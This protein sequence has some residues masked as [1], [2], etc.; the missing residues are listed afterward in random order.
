MNKERIVFSQLMDLFPRHDFNQCVKRYS[1][2]LIPRKFSFFDQYL[3]MSY[4]QVTFRESLRDIEVCL[5]SLGAKTYHM[6]FRSRVTRSTLAYANDTRDWRIWHDFAQ[7]LITRARTLYAGDSL[8]IQFQNAAYAIDSTTITLCLTLFP[9]ARYRT[10]A[11]AIKLHTQLDLRGNIPS[12]IL[13][14]HAKMSDVHF[15][16]EII[17]EPG[18][19]YIMDRGYFDFARFFRF[20][21]EG[22]FFVTRLKTNVYYR[23]VEIFSRSRT[24]AV[25]L[26]TA[27]TPLSK[28]AKKD[29]PQRLRLIE[30]FDIE[31]Q[32]LFVFITNNFALSAQAIA[33]FYRA[34]WKVELFFKWIK[35]HLR[36]KAFFGT[37]ENA[38][39]SQIW[40][41]ISVYALV[42]IL[43]KELKLEQSLH[44]ILQV[45]SACSVEKM[46]ILSA[47][48]DVQDELLP[49]KQSNQL[50]L[51][52][53]PIGH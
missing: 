24:G 46:P 1:V 42:A 34:R 25:R 11:R 7:I 22:A 45:L 33:D 9:W 21:I 23:R 26:D 6:G 48:R 37:S 28:N 20:T 18:A 36:I 17:I 10:Q 27:I 49:H 31:H 40:I 5:A 29:Y 43:K 32:K 53:I 12:F 41:A 44:T 15:L 3:S 8:D 19:L 4:A 2:G 51:F 50:N 35:Q 30:Y 52:N 47:F 14:S 39:R 13:I 16:D 38:V